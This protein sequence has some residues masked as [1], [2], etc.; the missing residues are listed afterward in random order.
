MVWLV[1]Q[2]KAEREA[3]KAEGLDLEAFDSTAAFKTIQRIALSSLLQRI[4]NPKEME[5]LSARTSAIF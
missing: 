1:E 2:S 4:K 5:T 3:L